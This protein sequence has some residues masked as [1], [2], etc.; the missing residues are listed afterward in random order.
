M[1]L[2]YSDADP[3]ELY[4]YFPTFMRRRD[5]LAGVDNAGEAVLQ[6][7]TYML[8]KES[9]AHVEMLRRLLL[10]LDVDNCSASRFN[11]LGYILGIPIPGDW[12]DSRRRM[13]LKQIPDLL[14]IKGTHLNFARQ[15][16][17][18][19][20]DI[21]LVELWKT[22]ENEYRRYSQTSS[23]AYNLK[24]ARVDMMSCSSS[25]CESIC[26]STCEA[27][28]QLG[29]EYVRPSIAQRLLDQLGEVLP[30]HVVLRRQAQFV[31]RTD[32]FYP[33]YDTLGCFSLCQ[34]ICE[35]TCEAQEQAWPG[36]YVE[37]D[38]GESGPMPYDSWAYETLCVTI[39]ES[40]CQTCCECGQEGTCETLCEV[41]CQ[42]V[43]ETVCQSTCMAA[44]QSVCQ[45]ACQTACA[46]SCQLICVTTCQDSCESYCEADLE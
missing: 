16:A 33:S 20:Q 11:Y 10:E 14:K 28:F 19:Q 5:E 21:W 1:A 45:S 35:D 36:S 29:G 27:G 3:L 6:K 7:I 4:R 30:V 24:S 22:E 31:E 8:E 41:T 9:G 34:S 32:A 17:F 42:V 23:S 26:E 18:H 13:Y 46:A 25:S 40:E 43:C 39:C 37:S 38:F 15:A 44:C 12:S 2:P